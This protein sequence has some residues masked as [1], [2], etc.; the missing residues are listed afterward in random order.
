MV[1]AD[2]NDVVK[3]AEQ[4]FAATQITCSGISDE[5]GRICAH[6]SLIFFY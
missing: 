6:F 4:I 1:F 5:I 3:N 2:E